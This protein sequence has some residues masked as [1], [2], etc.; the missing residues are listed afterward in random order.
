MLQDK[1]VSTLPLSFEDHLQAVINLNDAAVE[2]Y[3]NL[4][5]HCEALENTNKELAFL[6]K[7][8]EA[9]NKKAT[10]V[11][12]L[13]KKELEML[14]VAKVTATDKLGENKDLLARFKE[15]AATPKKIR[16]KIKKLQDNVVK[17]TAAAQGKDKQLAEYRN[18]NKRLKKNNDDLLARIAQASL[19]APLMYEN[20]DILAVWPRYY[21]KKAQ[22]SMLYMSAE[23]RGSLINIDED[24]EINMAPAP[25]RGLRPTTRTMEDAETI[26]KRFKRQKWE[27][28]DQDIE[29]FR[30]NSA[31]RFEG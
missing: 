23:G 3:N 21:G 27:I 30:A 15:I 24:S 16:E 25:K 31:V 1:Q 26:L 11:L 10:E 29:W 14:H 7:E 12:V 9:E 18:E 28:T 20:G 8:Q 2:E 5:D 22:I 4:A 13:A 19:F 6:N 17:W